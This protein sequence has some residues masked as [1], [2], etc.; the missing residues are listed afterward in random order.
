MQVKNLFGRKCSF[1]D[2]F[3][4]CSKASSFSYSL[5]KIKSIKSG[6]SSGVGVRI[7]DGDF[8]RIE[9][10]PVSDEIS[11]ELADFGLR[12]KKPEF[13]L[14]MAMVEKFVVEL[15]EE[16]RQIGKGKIKNID[17]GFS[18][19]ASFCGI[20]DGEKVSEKRSFRQ[21]FFV[22]VITESGNEK[23][24]AYDH[25]LSTR[26]RD[27]NGFFA[28]CREK[29][30]AAARLALD[31]LAA[32]RPPSGA[33]PVLI[34]SAAGGTLIHEAIG[35]SLEADAVRKGTSP[36]YAGKINSKVASSEITV[37][38]DAT[39]PDK[40]GSYE[41][42]DEGV[43][44]RKVFL[45]EKGVLKNYLFDRLEANLRNI[46]SNGH[47]RRE[48]P[49]AKPIP[50]MGITYL[51]PGK[52]DFDEMMKKIKK[53]LL[54]KKMG[55]GQVNP[56]NGDFV[57]EVREGYL[58]EGGRMSRLVKK[59]TIAGNGPK[60]LREIKYVGGKVGYDDGTCGKDGQSVPVSDG[61][62]DTLIPEL[63]VGG[64]Q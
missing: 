30:I 11:S 20:F 42:D 40:N 53:G 37:I 27:D 31:L 1:R 28:A 60:V 15:D 45:I 24:I 19:A 36:V 12:V 4:A 54:V 5:S 43:P 46:P 6:F 23:E 2:I 61:M 63:I 7:V 32:P 14:D 48:S 49:S 41:I 9:S 16:L 50:R 52:S 13:S 58:V 47:G 35:H 39:L 62:P 33:F 64:S 55:G 21:K 18:A 44:A 51:A 25:F 34:S 26:P 38:D 59:A 3:L 22:S 10:F 8:T 17:F 29:S 56:A 57:F